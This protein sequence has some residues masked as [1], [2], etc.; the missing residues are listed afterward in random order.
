MRMFKKGLS[1]PPLLLLLKLKLMSLS[2]GILYL[3]NGG[4]SGVFSSRCTVRAVTQG[5]LELKADRSDAK[6]LF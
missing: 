5:Y 3:S 1:P 4:E 2:M 6:W